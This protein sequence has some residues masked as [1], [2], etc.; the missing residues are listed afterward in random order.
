VASGRVVGI[1]ALCA[2]AAVVATVGGT[3]LL[4][5]H[6]STTSPVQG[7]AGK[8]VLQ[9]ELGERHDVEA[10]ALASAQTLLNRDGQPAEA[11]AIFKRYSSVEGRLGLAFA[12]WKGPES[13]AGVEAIAASAP[14]SPAALLNLG[15]AK[16]WAGQNA[17]AVRAW[18]RT[19]ARFPDSPY[20]IDALNALHPNVAPGLPVI[21]PDPSALPRNARSAFAAGNKYWNLKQIVTA[22]R[23]FNRAAKQAPNSPETVVTAAVSRFSPDKPLA[24]F[25][26]LGPLTVR[27]PGN[28]IVRFYLGELLLW[29]Q[30]VT[31]GKKQLRLAAA[32]QP[33]SVYAKQARAI[34]QELGQK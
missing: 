29:T 3:V 30:Q 10:G 25:P 31:R 16:F 34:L 23:Y 24:P 18:E 32:E 1:V 15:W 14:N 26:L 6:E 8:P 33:S 27:F 5:R 2:V 28:P 17:G 19:A 9:L 12:D 7:R 22:R 4:S 20:A 21:V 13:L 11:A